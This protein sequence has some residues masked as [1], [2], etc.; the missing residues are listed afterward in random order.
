[1]TS[2]GGMGELKYALRFRDFVQDMIDRT[3]ARI[4]PEP[5]FGKVKTLN[6]FSATCEVILNGDTDPIKC[7]ISPSV[8]PTYSNE[9]S[10][11]PEGGDIVKV[12]G[13]PGSYWITQIIAGREF[14]VEPDIWHPY[15]WGG[16]LFHIPVL[17][18]QT[19][20][21]GMPALNSTWHMGR[22]DNTGSFLSDGNGFIEVEIL[23]YL[24]TSIVKRYLIPIS[25]NATN[26]TW[27]KTAPIL[28]TGPYADDD[29]QLEIM[30]D[31]TGYELRIRRTQQ[32]PGSTPGGFSMRMWIYMDNVAPV[33]ASDLGEQVTTEPTTFIGTIDHQHQK[34][35]LASPMFAA[36]AMAQYALTGGGTITWDGT[37]L[38]WSQPFRMGSIGLGYN[39]KSGYFE[40]AQPGSGLA[41]SIY[42]TTV[43]TGVFSVTAGIPLTGNQSLWYEPPWGDVFTSTDNWRIVDPN[44]KEFAVP[45][46]WIFIAQRSDQ[47]GTC[48]LK[49]GTG[50]QIDHWRTPTLLNSWVNWGSGLQAAGYK[51]VD[52]RGVKLR[53]LVKAGTVNTTIF[54]LPAGYRP[55]L[56][57][58]FAVQNGTTSGQGRVDV[59]SSGNVTQVSG[60]SGASTFVGLSTILFYLD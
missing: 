45:A 25:Y 34:G 13:R 18:F 47:S 46:H 23:E 49:L 9:N 52:G 43:T 5:R 27:Q 50:E 42:G 60:V 3:I 14:Q 40:A 33:A 32:G 57:E 17:R 29:F 31:T 55:A 24:F 39:C 35:P 15:I 59:N 37:N 30:T 41:I 21:A 51:M 48:S 11:F 56:S 53:G 58:V 2:P 7:N 8:Q 19:Y 10:P 36:P 22:W 6:R 26:A 44:N 1:M 54:T 28:D 4:R 16:N 20:E 38:G 12:E